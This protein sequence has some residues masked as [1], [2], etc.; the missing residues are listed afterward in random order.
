MEIPKNLHGEELFKFLKTNKKDIVY[1]KKTAI[2]YADSFG[3]AA[4]DLKPINKNVN[5]SASE[6]G[7]LSIKRRLIINTTNVVDSHKDVHID[8]IWNKSLKENRNI[9]FLQEHEMSFKSIIADK[10]D[11]EASVNKVSWKSLGFDL[12]GKTEALTFDATIKQSR[13]SQMFKEYKDGNIDQHSVGMNYVSIKLAINSEEEDY[14][15][16]KAVWDKYYE[17]I[18]NK[19]E[20]EK[21]PYFWAITEAKVIEGSAVVLGSNGFTPTQEV[22]EIEVQEEKESP[23]VKWLKK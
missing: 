22:K 16:E 8:G 13:N 18:A 17:I 21:S 14:A 20:L 1:A 5:K 19:A 6:E 12:E 7:A 10:E 3:G 23:L 4:V 15:E 9:K 11:L 2:K